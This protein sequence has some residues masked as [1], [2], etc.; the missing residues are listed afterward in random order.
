MTTSRVSFDSWATLNDTIMGGRSQAGCRLTPEGLLLEGEVV[1]D[2]GGFV[3]CRSPLLQTPSR[4][5]GFQRIAL[6]DRSR[7]ANLE[8]CSGLL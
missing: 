4:S 8:I 3:S 7:R 1:A 6:S 2:G 5:F